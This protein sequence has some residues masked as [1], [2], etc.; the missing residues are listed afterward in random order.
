MTPE[1]AAALKAQNDALRKQ[2]EESSAREAAAKAAARTQEHVA[3]AEG[4]ISAGKV[5]EADKAGIVAIADA[6]NPAAGEPVMFSEGE[7]SGAST[8]TLFAK[9]KQFL[10]GLAPRVEFG[11]A[12]T[13]NR[14]AGADSG[15]PE[16]AYAEGADPERVALDKKIRAYMAQHNVGYAQAFRAVAK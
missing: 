4:L 6:I 11:E 10:E 2:V 7:G 15:A 13:R 8:T 16:V 12:A 14:A 5:P 9:F 1:E 3:F